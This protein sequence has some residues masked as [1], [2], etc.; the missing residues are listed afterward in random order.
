MDENIVE[1]V[2]D[3]QEA[4]A[5]GEQVRAREE[6]REEDLWSRFSGMDRQFIPFFS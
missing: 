5:Q 1:P 4:A 6:E 2:V 3:E